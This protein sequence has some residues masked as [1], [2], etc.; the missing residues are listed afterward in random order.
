VTPYYDDRQVTI[1]C[2]DCRD[3]LPSL[4]PSDV[5]LVTDPPYGIGLRSS[6]NGAHGDCHID[7]DESPALRDL[8]LAWAAGRPALVFGTWRVERPEGVRAVLIWDKGDHTGMGDLAF[9]WKP[10]HEEIYVL[11]EGFAGRRTSGVLHHLALAGTVALGPRVAEGRAHPMAKP[12]ALMRDLLQKCPPGVIV[13]PFMG[14]GT[15][16]RA[17]KDLGI[18]AIGIEINEAYC[19]I[20]V[21]RLAQGVLL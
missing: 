21:K 14:S 18:R 1:Y 5:V 13:D 16:L 3:V 12:V 17:A 2:G 6:R 10:N 15:T 19:E 11:G 8:A 9:P 7:G 4:D 20:A